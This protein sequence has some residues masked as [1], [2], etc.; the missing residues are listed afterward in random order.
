MKAKLR[1]LVIAALCVVCMGVLAGCVSGNSQADEQTKNRQYMSSVNTIMETLNTNMESFA[2]AVKDDEVVSLSS[3]L[4]AVDQ[5]ISSLEA[6]EVPDA[7]ADIH[8]QYVNG[9]KELQTALSSYVQL[10]E[11]VKAPK[12]G[13]YDYSDYE[14]RMADIQS[15]Y[16]AGIQALQDAD[17]KVQSA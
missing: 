17:S 11:D 12:S 2:K 4:S 9:A 16:N 5:C 6:L 3:Q 1:F 8:S 13:S 15:H 7:M 14:S 10:Y